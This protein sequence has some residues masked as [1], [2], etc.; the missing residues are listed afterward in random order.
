[1]HPAAKFLIGL[2]AAII[3]A[4]VHYGPM[5]GGEAYLQS[6]EARA[7][8]AVASTELPVEV[9]LDRDPPSRAA[10]LSGQ[11]DPFQREGQG[12]LKG[13]NDLVRETE[14]VSGV[15]WQ[16][17]AEPGGIPLLAEQLLWTL[18]AYIVGVVVGLL[19]FGRKR[20]TSYLD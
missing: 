11:A 2:L 15:T 17:E 19:V 4:W 16:G 1:M 13:L 7:R 6:I 14:G 5:G 3:V 18:L 8:A 9:R 20:R 12:E 10:I